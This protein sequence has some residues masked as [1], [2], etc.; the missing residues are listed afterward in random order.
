MADIAAEMGVA[1][2]SLY[3][4]VESK[5]ALFHWIVARGASDAPLAEP[6][7]LPIPT[8]APDAAAE[9]VRAQLAAAFELPRFEAACA[10]RRPHDAR[11]ELHDVL[12]ELYDRIAGAR[13]SMSVIERSAIDLPDLF[14]TY[15]AKL[16]RRYFERLRG[17]IAAR[18]R[19]GDFR[20]SLDP[21][22]A[23]RFVVEAITF[24]ARHRYGDPNPPPL[25]ADAE[26]RAQVIDLAS[27]SLLE[28]RPRKT[29]KRR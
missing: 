6:P 13:R 9:R 26:V 28:K 8:P 2:G 27:A 10:R 14:D 3:N 12:G 25:P 1:P 11:S 18:Q 7:S 5:E 24:F 19:T 20:A 16:R 17:Y 29:E 21:D 15:F 22:V 23:A 4:Y